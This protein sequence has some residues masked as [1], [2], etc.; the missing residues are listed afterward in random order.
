MFENSWKIQKFLPAECL[1]CRSRSFFSL[2]C[3]SSHYDRSENFQ[4]SWKIGD[5][6]SAAVEAENLSQNGPKRDRLLYKLEE[7][8]VKRLAGDLDGSVLALQE[9][10]AEYDRWFGVHLKTEA[11]VSEAV[12]SV[13]GSA[14]WKPYKSRVYERVMMRVYQALNYLQLD[15]KGRARAEIFKSRQAIEDSREIW[16][17]ELTA[18]QSNMKKKG[19]DLDQGINDKGNNPLSEERMRIRA[20]VPSNLP[21]YVNPAAIYLES[22]YFLRTGS[23]RDDFEKASFSLRQL[24]ALFP[25][26]EWIQEDF[27]SEERHACFR[28]GY[29][30]FLRD[31]SSS[32]SRRKAV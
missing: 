18:A 26:N 31:R 13:V 5:F 11:R 9:A 16:K 23:R 30:C 8:S 17:K 20:M 1:P 21:D 15:D 7:G 24:S 28:F 32:G 19:V 14:E 3:V 25:K 22:L 6:K 4:F 27:P 12:S 29:L 2:G 10:S